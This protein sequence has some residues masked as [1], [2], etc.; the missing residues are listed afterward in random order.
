MK[1]HQPTT[2]QETSLAVFKLLRPEQLL[3]RAG[4]MSFRV[5]HLY[6]GNHLIKGVCAP[7]MILMGSA[8]SHDSWLSF[9]P[10]WLVS[11]F[12]L[13]TPS[14]FSPPLS[15]PFSASSSLLPAPFSP[16]L[17]WTLTETALL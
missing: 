3:L 1:R 6:R 7:D 10:L 16:S 11:Y 9:S 4:K 15:A 17:S 13:L 8:E 2:S 5:L 14:S 12:S